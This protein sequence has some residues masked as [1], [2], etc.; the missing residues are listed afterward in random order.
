MEWDYDLCY[1]YWD[2]RNWKCCDVGEYYE[3]EVEEIEDIEEEID[4][5]D[6]LKK[7]HYNYYKTKDNKIFRVHISYYQGVLPTVDEEWG[8]WKLESL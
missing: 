2:G 4:D 7:Y 5:P 6:Y 8:D 3:L 1:A